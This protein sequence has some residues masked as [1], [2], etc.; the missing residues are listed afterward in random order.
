VICT[1]LGRNGRGVDLFEL[2]FAEVFLAA[3]SQRTKQIRLAHDIIQL[4]TVQPA[5]LA[6]LLQ[7]QPVQP[8][9]RRRKL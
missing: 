8:M 2:D 3:A 9:A 1:E 5:R 7:D 6:A 4:T